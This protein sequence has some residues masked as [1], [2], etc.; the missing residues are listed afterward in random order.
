MNIKN[1]KED[2]I[3]TGIIE[4]YNTK[5]IDLKGSRRL[6]INQ[7]ELNIKSPNIKIEQ[8]NIN[9]KKEVSPSTILTLLETIVSK[10]KSIPFLVYKST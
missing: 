7:P 5:N 9:I 3:L 4:G 1:K 2:F 6:D 10:S 8:Q